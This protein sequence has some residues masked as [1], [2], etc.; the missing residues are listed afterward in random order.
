M[1]DFIFFVLFM[2]LGAYLMDVPS[3]DG[4]LSVWVQ[5]LIGLGCIYLVGYFCGLRKKA[6]EK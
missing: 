3:S 1:T 5:H 6:S 2:L 4:V